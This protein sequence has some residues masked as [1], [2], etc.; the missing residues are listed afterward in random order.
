MNVIGIKAVIRVKRK[1]YL[2]S[3]AETVSENILDK[4][5]TS[6][7]L[8]EKWLTDM[9]EFKVKGTSNKYYLSS[10]ID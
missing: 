9:S 6:L 1:T 2:Y 4:N 7:R 10:I 8:N 5:F 3:K